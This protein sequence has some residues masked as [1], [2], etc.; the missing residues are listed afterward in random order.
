[1]AVSQSLTLTETDVLTS[2]NS[3]KVRILWKSTQ[4]GES[5]N[6]YTRTAIYYVSINGGTETKYTVNYTLPQNS[7]ATIVDTTLLVSHK[8]NGTGI[9][10]VRT[11]MDTGI[12]AGIVEKNASLTLTL[13]P[14]EAT[15]NSLTCPGGYVGETITAYYTPQ[16]STYYNRCIV[17]VNVNNTL[18]QIRAEKL[19]QKP[20]PYNI[21][22]TGDE[23]S[24]TIYAKVTNTTTAVIRVTF[25]TYSDSGYKTK[26]G[27]DQSL[28]ISLQLPLSVAPTVS[29]TVTPVNSNSWIAGKNIYVAG[30]SSAT[31]TLSATSGAGISAAPTTSITCN[32]VTSSGTKL[33]AVLKQS[34]TFKFIGKATDSRGR[35]ATDEETINVLAYST[36]IVTSMVAERGTYN[37]GWTAKNDGEDVQ[38]KFKTNLSLG[39]QGNR[40]SV[41]FERNANTTTVKAGTTTGLESGKEYTVYLSKIDSE[42]SHT[43]KLTATDSVGNAGVATI[44]VQ[45]KHITMEFNDSGKGIAFGK[46]SEMEEGFECAWDAEFH[47]TVK[48]IRD[49]GS[50]L[51][52]D[53]TGWID[54]GISDAV[55]TTSSTSAG[56][57][58]GCAYRVVNGNHVYVAFNVR[59][60]YSGSAVTVSKN[61]IP[62]EYRPKLQPYAIVTLNGKRVSRILVSRTT[63]H[64]MIDWIHNVADDTDGTYTPEPEVHTATW[65]DGYID[66]FI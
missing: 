2:S 42:T 11:W 25:Q 24:K 58:V 8:T 49:D 21:K 57:Y 34:G 48:R 33:E 20:S 60:E 22:F 10:T 17:Y 5:R 14:R 18:T 31:A 4:T 66:Y 51:T 45:T 13:I 53:D 46:T 43:L 44:T 56:H 15:L 59:A 32:G 12:S 55:T 61:P 7:T 64:A 1:M 38:V 29:L 63:G 62:S 23:L 35:T 26:I 39:D 19:D 30:L 54:L 6:E 41:A 40:Y 16:N 36:P 28:E 27:S 47:G 9:V 3:S 65:I 37:S 52:L 50:I